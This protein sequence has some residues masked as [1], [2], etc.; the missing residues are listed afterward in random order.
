MDHFSDERK[1]SSLLYLV[2]N[3]GECVIS[4]PPGRY[5]NPR[6]AGKKQL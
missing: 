2:I 3:P 5:L 4:E 6:P 1:V